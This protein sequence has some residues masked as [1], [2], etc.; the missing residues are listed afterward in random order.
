M[1]CSYGYLSFCHRWLFFTLIVIEEIV[2][3]LLQ[4]LSS[5]SEY[6]G[7][8]GRRQVIVFLVSVFRSLL[9]D[10]LQ[11]SHKEIEQYTTYQAYGQA[12]G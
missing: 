6:V 4:W 3:L 12:N 9:T 10:D 1:F 2:I 5:T 7:H 8:W 11:I